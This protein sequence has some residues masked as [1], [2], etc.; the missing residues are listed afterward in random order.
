MEAGARVLTPSLHG[1]S[2][3]F[4][5]ALTMASDICRQELSNAV[6][7]PDLLGS[8]G[9]A[10]A[11]HVSV[12]GALAELPLRPRAGPAATGRRSTFEDDP[13]GELHCVRPGWQR[14]VRGVQGAVLRVVEDGQGTRA[15][16]A[17][18]MALLART[19]DLPQI[20]APYLWGWVP[21]PDNPELGVWWT[22]GP[23]GRVQVLSPTDRRYG[24]TEA[25]LAELG[26]DNLTAL[27]E[28]H[29]QGLILA[30][31]RLPNTT[32][33]GQVAMLHDFD[34]LADLW[35]E[36]FTN[37]EG[38]RGHPWEVLRSGT[39]PYARD[40]VWKRSPDRR[41]PWMRDRSEPLRPELDV[42]DLLILLL[43]VARPELHGHQMLRQVTQ[44]A[45]S[46]TPVPLQLVRD[47]LEHVARRHAGRLEKLAPALP[48]PQNIV[49]RAMQGRTEE[50]AALHEHLDTVVARKHL[51]R[52]TAKAEAPVKLVTGPPGGGKT[53]LLQ[54]LILQCS[55]RRRWADPGE[56]VPSS[57]LAGNLIHVHLDAKDLRAEAFA[58]AVAAQLGAVASPVVPTA[59]PRIGDDTV[60]P[61]SAAALLDAVQVAARDRDG[62]VTLVIDALDSSAGGGAQTAR[63]LVWLAER[64]PPGSLRLVITAR[65]GSAAARILAASPA[66][67][68]MPLPAWTGNM[69]EHVRAILLAPPPVDTPGQENRRTHHTVDPW[70]IDVF[71]DRIARL[72]GGDFSVATLYALAVAA[73]GEWPEHDVLPQSV[74][75]EL[76]ARLSHDDVDLCDV[77]RPLAYM[78]AV[79]A[80]DWLKMVNHG[81]RRAVAYTAEEVG[82]PLCDAVGADVGPFLVRDQGTLLRLTAEPVRRYIRQRDAAAAGLFHPVEIAEHLASVEQRLSAIASFGVV[83]TAVSSAAVAAPPPALL[84]S[85][86]A[87]PVSVPAGALSVQTWTRPWCLA[88]RLGA[89]GEAGAAV[90]MVIEHY[91]HPVG[92]TGVSAVE[93]REGGTIAAAAARPG[94]GLALVISDR[95][96]DPDWGMLWLSRSVGEQAVILQTPVAYDMGCW[97]GRPVALCDAG[98]ALVLRDAE[99]GRSMGPV[100]PWRG[101]LGLVPYEQ[102]GCPA[103]RLR[104]VSAV[105]R[106]F[107]VELRHGSV[108]LVPLTFDA[109]VVAAATADPAADLAS[110]AWA[111]PDAPSPRASSLIASIPTAATCASGGTWMGQPAVFT[112][113]TGRLSVWCARTGQLG[114]EMHVPGRVSDVLGFREGVFIAV[115]NVVLRLSTGYTP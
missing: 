10:N 70:L 57:R 59:G 96:H 113:A 48:R 81:R 5:E 89:V 71:A 66:V 75:A 12:K 1:P 104:L 95:N 50:L 107:A 83:A 51:Q 53:R 13:C 79:D 21:R 114:H 115:D 101:V 40:T 111:Q 34:T 35:P 103:R 98:Q 112:V 39:E 64:A 33:A 25:T 77:L 100:V 86:Q 36:R 19:D 16:V 38:P 76:A 84:S 88:P 6:S 78:P 97:R 20:G 72:A 94:R 110:R 41:P 102:P 22:L 29:S 11:W 85:G 106:P 74:S 23:V 67:A 92:D 45:A 8:G 80:A 18:P 28:L 3:S 32:L 43:E 93:L 90:L 69:S 52:A 105:D 54:A 73:V 31:N 62:T 108:E 7:D 49:A 17:A 27:A 4:S 61:S 87:P 26:L 56:P 9:F 37:D 109:P 42:W 15:E 24:A 63:L 44:W 99:D 68:V 58:A 14:N 91:I 82:W 2:L 65:T 30:D 46:P 47:L 60:L 55:D